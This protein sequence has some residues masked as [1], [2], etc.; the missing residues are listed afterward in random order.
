MSDFADFQ[1]KCTDYYHPDSEV[2]LA[3]DDPKVGIQWPLPAGESPRLSG[4]DANGLNWGEAPL[5]S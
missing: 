2:S 1:Y 5:L 4:K 3:W